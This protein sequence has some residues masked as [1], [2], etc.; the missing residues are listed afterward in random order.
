MNQFPVVLASYFNHKNDPQRG[1]LWDSDYSKLLP[2]VHSVVSRGVP[3][4]IFHN[5]FTGLPEIDNCEWIEVEAD[6]T[7]TPNIARYFE[8]L[9]YLTDNL[10]KFESVFMVDSTDVEMLKNPF[11][12]IKPGVLYVGDEIRSTVGSKWMQRTQG[13]YL[14]IPDY[15]QII[16]KHRN[17]V[18]IN[19]GIIGGDILTVIKFLEQL[20]EYHARYSKNLTTSSDMSV[21]NYTVWKHFKNIMNRGP[22]VNTRFKRNERNKIAW[23]KHK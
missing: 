8:Y 17:E 5:C 13:K 6:P 9:T 19:C 14:D 18:L 7:L 16:S 4:K 20:T 12:H 11:D 23:W 21:F 3:I 1:I 2:L 22:H 15:L 10:D